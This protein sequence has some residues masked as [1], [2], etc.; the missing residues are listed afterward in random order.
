MKYNVLI[1]YLLITLN[2]YSQNKT[3][4]KKY[5]LGESITKYKTEFTHSGINELGLDYYKYSAADPDIKSIFG[6]QLKDVVLMV[7][8]KNN[9][10]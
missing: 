9:I 1:S 3:S 10:I 5:K 4:F 6:V 7:N 8:P 2:C